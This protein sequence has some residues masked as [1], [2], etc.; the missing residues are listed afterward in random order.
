MEGNRRIKLYKETKLSRLRKQFVNSETKRLQ[1]NFNFL[2]DEMLLKILSY[3]DLKSLLNASCVCKNW[4]C[5]SE[6]S[7][8]WNHFYRLFIVQSLKN[9]SISVAELE[10]KCPTQSNAKRNFITRSVFLRSY[11]YKKKSFFKVNDYTFVTD[12]LKEK[13]TILSI[14]FELC[15]TSVSGDSYFF[16]GCR[17]KCLGTSVTVHWASMENFIPLTSIKNIK[18][19]ALVPIVYHKY[20]KSL[21][22]S[23]TQ[24]K[25][26]LDET[27][28]N[29][30][31]LIGTSKECTISSDASIILKCLGPFSPICYGSWKS[32]PDN[33][34]FVTATLQGFNLLKTCLFGTHQAVFNKSHVVLYDDVD[35]MYGLH[36]Y[37]C[38]LHIHSFDASIYQEKI[39]LQPAEQLVK[40]EEPFLSKGNYFK[41]GCAK[42]PFN[43]CNPLT[44][45]WKTD[46][47]KGYLLRTCVIDLVLRDSN[48]DVFWSNSRI[49]SA[50]S[51]DDFPNH[52]FDTEGDACQI[53]LNDDKVCIC[54]YCYLNDDSAKF[55]LLNVYVEQGYLNSW[56]G[57]S[58]KF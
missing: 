5:L 44:F 50:E 46:L 48:G 21:T 20:G 53:L 12:K 51:I 26:I 33:I 22:N 24:K 58:Y 54:L 34:A 16:H 47:F 25:L 9:I 49:A 28:V 39:H 41:L 36:S 38:N 31:R 13:L 10:S 14:N 57:T 8:L 45:G 30:L 55:S 18:I 43:H 2:P 19:Y 29:P 37:V 32:N 6:S 17:K 3:L 15:I 7:I 23:P 35:K 52:A 56:F 27:I 4:L 11:L 42:I 1:T 40:S